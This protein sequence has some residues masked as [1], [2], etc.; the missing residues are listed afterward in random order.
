M[1]TWNMALI[2]LR[3]PVFLLGMATA[4]EQ[5]EDARTAQFIAFWVTIRAALLFFMVAYLT[6]NE[7]F[8]FF[9]VE[10]NITN[11]TV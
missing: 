7:H 8:M 3:W 5:M 6:F 1:G 10:V 9:M 4:A 2:A 11:T